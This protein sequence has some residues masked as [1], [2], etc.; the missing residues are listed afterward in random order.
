MKLMLVNILSKYEV[1][2]CEKTDIPM[3]FSKSSILVIPKNETVW[4]NFRPL[5]G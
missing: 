4:L 2:P 1:E 3:K 5:S